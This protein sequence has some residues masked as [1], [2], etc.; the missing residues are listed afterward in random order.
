MRRYRYVV[1]FRRPTIMNLLTFALKAPRLSLSTGIGTDKHFVSDTTVLFYA[2]LLATRSLNVFNTF[3]SSPVG[4]IY[5]RIQLP[6]QLWPRNVA[7]PCKSRRCSINCLFRFSTTYRH[8]SSFLIPRLG[9]RAMQMLPEIIEH[10]V[11]ML[12]RG[13]ARRMGDRQGPS[14]LSS[15]VLETL[16]SCLQVNHAF[17]RPARAII[18]KTVRIKANEDTPGYFGRRLDTL[19]DVLRMSNSDILSQPLAKV[20]ETFEFDSSAVPGS[21][22]GHASMCAVFTSLAFANSHINGRLTKLQVHLPDPTS[23]PQSGCHRCIFTLLKTARSVRVLLLAG[24]QGMPTGIFY[25]AKFDRAKILACSFAF[26]D[27]TV[28]SS[29]EV[30]ASNQF[31]SSTLTSLRRAQS[32]ARRHRTPLQSNSFRGTTFLLSASQTK[33]RC[34]ASTQRV[35]RS[36]KHSA[37]TLKSRVYSFSRSPTMYLL[38]QLETS[39]LVSQRSLPVFSALLGPSSWKS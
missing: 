1:R 2:T 5:T 23:Q 24:L 28:N 36:I 32:W 38:T 17:R 3:C 33:W 30:G 6:N 21:V 26:E 7:V 22:L 9:R 12:V 20:I 11:D 4:S 16:K 18:F 27:G 10:I 31:Q 34:L 13:E 35:L 25:G 29:S 19:A 15:E 37:P 14:D 8:T 39:T